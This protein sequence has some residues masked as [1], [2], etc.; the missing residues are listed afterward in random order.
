LRHVVPSRRETGGAGVVN[1]QKGHPWC[2]ACMRSSFIS[3]S[4]EPYALRSSQ[5]SMGTRDKLCIAALPHHRARCEIISRFLS[6]QKLER[7]VHLPHGVRA[8]SMPMK[9]LAEAN[10]KM[11]DLCVLH[12]KQ[13]GSSHRQDH[14]TKARRDYQ[15]ALNFLAE[16]LGS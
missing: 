14:T 16:L 5:A 6:R 13:C 1:E 12:F 2:T 15:H 11:R 4:R 3:H 9:V 8:R 7:N 10:G